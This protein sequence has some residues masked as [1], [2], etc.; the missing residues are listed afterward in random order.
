MKYFIIIVFLFRNAC[1]EGKGRQ[2][3]GYFCGNVGNTKSLMVP[4]AVNEWEEWSKD[5][6]RE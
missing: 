3:Y 6:G 1:M 5:V 2:V 4:V